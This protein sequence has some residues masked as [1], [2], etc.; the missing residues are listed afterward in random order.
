MTPRKI[1]NFE[2]IEPTESDSSSTH[3][4]AI[5]KQLERRV[6]VR[7]FHD[8]NP[9][10]VTKAKLVAL[11]DHPNLENNIDLIQ[12]ESDCYLV[13]QYE[14]GNLLSELLENSSDLITP[15][16]SVTLDKMSGRSLNGVASL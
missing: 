1:G 3:Y 14:Y 6:K 5:Q 11:L 8:S 7:A 13:S 10:V 15:L 12:F 4:Y 2:I 16:R 9:D